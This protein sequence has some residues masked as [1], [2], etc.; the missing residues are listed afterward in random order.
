MQ[1]HT[2]VHDLLH[3]SKDIKKKIQQREEGRVVSGRKGRETEGVGER[4]RERDEKYLEERERQRSDG[5]KSKTG[6]E[7]H[8]HTHTHTYTRTNLEPVVTKDLSCR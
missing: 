8:T 1:S 2:H 7:T 4:E 3:S 5:Q 6:G